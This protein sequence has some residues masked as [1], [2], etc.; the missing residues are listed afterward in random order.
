MLAERPSE[1]AEQYVCAVDEVFV[2]REGTIPNNNRSMKDLPSDFSCE[3]WQLPAERH[4]APANQCV[5]AVVMCKKTCQI[6][7]YGT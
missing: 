7:R 5:C 4:S 3:V 6:A 1:T 2:P